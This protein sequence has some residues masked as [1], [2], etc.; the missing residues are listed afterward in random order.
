MTSSRPTS[1]SPATTRSS[2]ETSGWLEPV[3]PVGEI[4]THAGQVQGTPSFMSPEQC[5]SEPVD[6]RADIYALGATYYALLTG[7]GPYVE[8]TAMLQVMFAHCYGPV[9]DPRGVLPGLPEACAA[10]VRR[11]MAKD[12]SCRYQTAEEML[13]DLEAALSGSERRAERGPKSI[14]EGDF[15]AGVPARVH[16]GPGR[17]PSSRISTRCRSRRPRQ[18]RTARELSRDSRRPSPPPPPT[19]RRGPGSNSPRKPGIGVYANR[20][21]CMIGRRWVGR[22]PAGSVRR[23]PPWPIP[24]RRGH[25]ARKHI[26]HHLRRI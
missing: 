10:I 7:A 12:P 5:Q 20:E 22:G 4:V 6:A 17:V 16:D 24:S 25:G 9:P 19:A 18:A 21:P 15:G 11:A 1:S 14:S 23:A 13:A 26:D 3:D 2:W 8:S